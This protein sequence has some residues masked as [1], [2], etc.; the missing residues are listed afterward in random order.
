MLSSPDGLDELDDYVLTIE[1]A[2]TSGLSGGKR[3]PSAPNG[4]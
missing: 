3:G 2:L 1:D 4:L